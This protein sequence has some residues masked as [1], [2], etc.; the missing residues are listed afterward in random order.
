KGYGGTSGF[1]VS[2]DNKYMVLCYA[3]GDYEK[4]SLLLINLENYQIEKVL[5]TTKLYGRSA[6][7]PDGKNFITREG[8]FD[9]QYNSYFSTIYIWSAETW[10]MLSKMITVQGLIEKCVFSHDN[11]YLLCLTDQS[12]YLFD[13][14]TKQIIREYKPVYK[15]YIGLYHN[16]V[17]FSNDSKNIIFGSYTMPK[18]EEFI[19]IIDVQTDSLKRAYRISSGSGL[20]ITSDDSQILTVENYIILMNSGLENTD[21][22]ENISSSNNELNI[23]YK[24]DSITL[25]FQLNS[26]CNARLKIH[27]LKGVLSRIAFTF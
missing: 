23:F 10:K 8:Y 12:S 1:A 15:N 11:K 20:D 21:V 25:N 7:S 14:Q 22:E 27:D 26:S 5:D 6:F 19:F 9:N 18:L 24:N 17:V 13:W 16:R 2:N 4:D 3:G